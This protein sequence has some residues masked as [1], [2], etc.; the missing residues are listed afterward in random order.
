MFACL[1]KASPFSILTNH[2]QALV[3]CTSRPLSKTAMM[4]HTKD[5][6][7]WQKFCD[8]NVPLVSLAI[9][10]T[11]SPSS[12]LFHK[13]GEWSINQTNLNHQDPKCSV[14]ELNSWQLLFLQG[15]IAFVPQ[16]LNSGQGQTF[17]GISTSQRHELP[18]CLMAITTLCS[19]FQDEGTSL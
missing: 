19:L 9:I 15:H 7:T 4:S 6:K 1:R 2:S 12:A 10:N 17:P 18:R 13:E 8:T 16:T 5:M 14:W 3:I 11:S